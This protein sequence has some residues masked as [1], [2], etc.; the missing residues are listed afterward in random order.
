[1]E[2]YAASWHNQ[3]LKGTLAGT[4]P[5]SMT[6]YVNALT[7]RFEDNDAREEAYAEL[8]NVRYEGSSAKTEKAFSAF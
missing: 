8:E 4:Y 6:G 7:L 5:K 3:W 1:M 2:S